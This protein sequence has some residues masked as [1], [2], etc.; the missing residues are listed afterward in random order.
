MRKRGLVAI[1]GI[2]LVLGIVSLFVAIPTRE[3]HGFD[4]GPVS[5]GVEVKTREKVHPAISGLLIAGGVVLI[6]L[7][8]RAKP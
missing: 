7:G 3:R 1:G 5:F 6:A 4:A 8:S 2:V